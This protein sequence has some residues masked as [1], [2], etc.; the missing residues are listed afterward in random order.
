MT[1]NF[2]QIISNAEKA[3]SLLRGAQVGAADMETRKTRKQQANEYLAQ[4]VAVKRWP[5]AY[6]QIVR[7]IEN[8]W[9][10]LI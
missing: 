9:F 3:I 4:L 1:T 2:D 8:E 10:N 6:Q 7:N 5:A